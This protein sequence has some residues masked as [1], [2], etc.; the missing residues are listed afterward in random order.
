MTRSEAVQLL[1]ARES[2]LRASVYLVLQYHGKP[3]G[4][5]W[6]LDAHR[7]REAVLG[8]VDTFDPPLFKKAKA[9]I[10]DRRIP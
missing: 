1:N 3:A 7:L 5:P 8:L 4:T 9:V 2:L 6:V 10:D